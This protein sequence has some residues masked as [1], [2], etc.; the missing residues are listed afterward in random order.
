MEG[1]RVVLI[2][3]RQTEEIPKIIKLLSSTIGIGLYA[4]LSDMAS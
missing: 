4:L 2:F 3:T 1:E